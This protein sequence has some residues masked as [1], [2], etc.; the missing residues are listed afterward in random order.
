MK[1][2]IFGILA[3]STLAFAEVGDKNLYMRAEF[4]GFGEYD[5]EGA[6]NNLV[7][8][9]FKEAGYSLGV[10]YMTE[11]MPSLEVG[12][13]TGYQWQGEFGYKLGYAGN[14][15]P[16]MNSIPLYATMKSSLAPI[17]MWTPYLKADLGFSFNDLSDNAHY[18]Y[19]NGIYYGIAFGFDIEDLSLELAYKTNTGKLEKS[20]GEKFDVKNS[21]IMLGGI[22]KFSL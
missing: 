16:E 18:K 2:I 5:L 13:G 1:K 10:E 22:Y 4:S 8:D 7:K 15:I 19:D 12:I 6:E 3:L 11:F 9:K 14:E 20:S 21:R 17:G